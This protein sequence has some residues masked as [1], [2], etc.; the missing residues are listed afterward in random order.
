ML[1]QLVVWS[2][3]GLAWAAQDIDIQISYIDSTLIGVHWCGTTADDDQ[4]VLVLTSKGSVYRSDD[5]GRTWSKLSE[6]FHRKGLAALDDTET[7]KVF[8]GAYMTRSAS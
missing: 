6:V 4:N 7:Q 5:K 3:A 2:L 8:M 1:S